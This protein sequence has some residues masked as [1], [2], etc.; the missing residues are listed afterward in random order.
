MRIN[1][2]DQTRKLNE[3]NAST[4]NFDSFVEFV[5]SVA[6]TEL[7]C[8]DINRILL[9]QALQ[10]SG[11]VTVFMEGFDEISPFYKHKAFAILYESCRL[12]L[13]EMWLR[14]VMWG[15]RDLKRSH[16]ASPSA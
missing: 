2:N 8:T 9:K 14:F 13:G 3:I 10:N 7:K 1:W 15:K 11:N 6:F 16:L 4:F 5:C 12:K